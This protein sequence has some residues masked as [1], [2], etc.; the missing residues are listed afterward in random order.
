P[1]VA[2]NGT[3]PPDLRAGLQAY[4]RESTHRRSF[5]SPCR[6]S[7]PKV[8]RTDSSPSMIAVRSSSTVPTTTGLRSA[9]VP[10]LKPYGF[11]SRL[12]R[13]TC[14]FYC[15][16]ISSTTILTYHLCYRMWDEGALTGSLIVLSGGEK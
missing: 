9:S 2:S 16:S 6:N 3:S 1:A 12:C 7:V 5:P 14:E 11:H 4:L 8:A 13:R 10:R 15:A